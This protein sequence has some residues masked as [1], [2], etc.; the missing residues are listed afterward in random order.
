MQKTV[1]FDFDGTIADSF[2]MVFEIAN[3]LADKFGY[4]K[5]S[6]KE[7]ER[8]KGSTIQKEMKRF[9]IPAWKLILILREARSI[10]GKRMGDIKPVEELI[11]KLEKLKTEG[12]ILGIVTSN[13]KENVEKFLERNGAE[14]FDFIVSSKSFFGKDKKI[15]KVITQRKINKEKVLYIG[16][17]VRDIEAA[18]KAGI[19]VI[20]VSWGLN[21]EAILKEHLPDA[22]VKR[23]RD[24][25]GAIEKLI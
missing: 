7:F 10:F 9:G 21:S 19:K 15:S 3:Q 22:F 8:I 20:A 11:E 4:Q 17:E 2:K 24:L 13:S 12:F 14:L 16:D 25:I 18:K 5:I 1:I 23:P 6:K